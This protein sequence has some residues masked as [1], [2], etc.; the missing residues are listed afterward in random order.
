MEHQQS[1]FV[2]PREQSKEPKRVSETEP[3]PKIGDQDPREQELQRV[4][5]QQAYQTGYE[6]PRG[7]P[8]YKQGLG[9][10]ISPRR[11]RRRTISWPFL[12]VV[13]IIILAL[14]G[15]MT[16]RY[17][18]PW[19]K[20]YHEH[21]IFDVSENAKLV[22]NNNHG[23]VYV[24]TG[25]YQH[26]LITTVTHVPRDQS[27]HMSIGA[28]ARKV[29]GR[30][31]A[32]DVDAPS[33]DPNNIASQVDLDITVP[34]TTSLAIHATQGVVSVENVKGTIQVA[35][36]QSNIELDSTEGQVSLT[37]GNGNIELS[38][39]QLSG[40]SALKTAHGNIDFAGSLDPYGSYDFETENGSTDITLPGSLAF[41]LNTSFPN[42]APIDND[43]RSTSVGDGQQANITIRTGSGHIAIH[44]D[45]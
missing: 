24:H 42:G 18:R 22:V 6:G 33:S 32:V 14:S 41:H 29:D 26:I 37:T 25:D 38:D 20:G 15:F 5:V 10:K 8:A 12:I 36:T 31:V 21:S 11:T 19:S 34:E 9:E 43:F 4:V 13:A 3:L 40:S 28:D 45:D 2:D 44:E 30:T 39:A 23:K 27:Q 35:T 7:G 16:A 1:F 17:D